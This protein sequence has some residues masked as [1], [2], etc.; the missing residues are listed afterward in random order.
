MATNL[1]Y[2][3]MDKTI[4]EGLICK[5]CKTP[6]LDPVSTPCRH[7]FCRQCVKD[8]LVKKPICSDCGLPLSSDNL[9]PMVLI[10][11]KMLDNLLVKCV[12]CEQTDIKRSQ[13][14]H[15]I[16]E[17]CPKTAVCCSAVDIRCPWKGRKSQLDT[18]KASCDYERLRPVLTELIAENNQLKQEKSPSS[19]SNTVVQRKSNIIQ[20]QSTKN[21]TIISQLT[22]KVTFLNSK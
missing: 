15:H 3:Y 9:V 4:D 13:F 21:S 10:V 5:I 19:I 18:H 2:E 1:K 11:C 6:F 22:K 7:A 17:I 20:N 8:H 12:G 16:E 14:D